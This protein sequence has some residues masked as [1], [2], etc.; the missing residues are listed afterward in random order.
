MAFGL[1]PRGVEHRQIGQRGRERS[2]AGRRA[3]GQ[4]LHAERYALLEVPILVRRNPLDFGLRQGLGPYPRN[5][6]GRFLADVPCSRGIATDRPFADITIMQIG[7]AEI[8]V[9]C[10]I[11]GE[12]APRSEPLG[13]DELEA[14][15]EIRKRRRHRSDA[16]ARAG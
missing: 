5:A 6:S 14:R 3:L 8:E 10:V 15:L 9:G 4:G 16:R 2:P 1:D 7:N 13:T 12:I 11:A